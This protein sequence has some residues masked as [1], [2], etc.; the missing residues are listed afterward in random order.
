MSQWGQQQGYG[1]GSYG[2][3]T[4]QT[5]QQAAGYGATQQTAQVRQSAVEVKPPYY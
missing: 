4:Q 3:Q 5:P 2:Q 1:Q